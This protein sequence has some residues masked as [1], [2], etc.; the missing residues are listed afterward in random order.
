[1]KIIFVKDTPGQG[2]KG[3]L[4]EVSDGFA[5]NFLIAK[6]FAQVAT[7]QIIAKVEKE[8]KEQD[9]K[10]LKEIEKL[11]N[12]KTELEKRTFTLNVKVGEQGQVFGGVHEKEIAHAMQ[13]KKFMEIN[14]NM[15]E[16]TAPIKT[17]GEHSVKVKLG[18]GIMANVKIMVEAKL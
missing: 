4:K 15:V 12:L 9:S 13:E 16:I 6:G 14:R 17:L 2:K 8:K 1:M 10:K 11:G 3:E 18:T 7:P 5:Q